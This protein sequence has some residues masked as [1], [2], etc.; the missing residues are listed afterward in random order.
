MHEV[1]RFTPAFLNFGRHVPVS[2]NFYRTVPDNICSDTPAK[3]ANVLSEMSEYFLMVQDRIHKAYE[4]NAKYYNQHRRQLEFDVGD[5]V[6]RKNR[7]LSVGTRCYSSALAPR[8]VL[9]KIVKKLSPLAYH[10]HDVSGT[11][12]GVHHIKDLKLQFR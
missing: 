5:V 6:Y 3:Y 4:R 10:L 12:V 2:G 9:S 7:V 11:D 1:T 8:Y